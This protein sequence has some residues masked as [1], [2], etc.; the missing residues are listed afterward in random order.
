MPQL[1]RFVVFVLAIGAC[2]SRSPRAPVASALSAARLRCE[3]LVE[4]LGID[5]RI[6]RLSWNLTAD[7]AGEGTTAFEIDARDPSGAVAWASGKVTGPQTLQAE[8]SGRVLV[9]RE[10][11]TWKV[12]AWDNHDRPG[13]WSAPAHFEMGLLDPADWKGRWVAGAAS[14]DY[15]SHLPMADA[16]T[17]W[18]W[19]DG[20][21]RRPRYFRMVFD[22]PSGRTTKSAQGTAAAGDRFVL[23]ANGREVARGA[24]TGILSPVNLSL[25]AGRNVVTAQVDPGAG[26][27]GLLLRVLIEY[28]VGPPTELR[29]GRM[30]KTSLTAPPGW[31]GPAF[32]DRDWVASK[33]LGGR[34]AAPFGRTVLPAQALPAPLLRKTFTIKKKVVSARAYISGLGYFELYCNGQRVGDHVLD[35]GFTRYDRRVLYVTHDV[36]KALVAG[37]NAVGVILGNGFFNTHWR[38]A[39]AFQD[40]PWKM[41]P[42]LTAQIEVLYQDGTRDVVVTD[43]SWQASTGALVFDGVR[44]GEIFDARLDK[45][46]FSH[47]DFDA[48]SWPRALPVPG[49]KGVMS[50]QMAPPIRVTETIRPIAVTQPRPG[51][52]VFDMGQ[53]IAGWARLRVSGPAGTTVQLRYGER[54]HKDGLLDQAVI[55][56]HVQ[57][58]PFQTDTYVLRGDPKGGQETWEPRFVYH[59]FQYVEVSGFPGT[60]TVASLDGRAVNT[61]FPQIG[62]FD[63]SNVLLNQI[64]QATI[65]SYRSN[66]HSIPTDCPHREKNGW[67]ADAHLST[68]LAMFLFDNGPG[69]SKWVRDITDEQRSDG[70]L[71]GIVPTAGWGYDWG[72]GPAW[73]SA[74]LLVPWYMNLYL[75]DTRILTSNY[76]AFN[77]YASYLDG[78]DYRKK[79]PSGWLGDWVHLKQQTPEAVTHAGFQARDEDILAQTARL[80]GN[81]TEANRHQAVASRVRKDFQTRLL[82][83]DGKISTG[84]QTAQACALFEH[85][86]DAKAAPAVLKSL[87]ENL[88]GQGGHLEAG[89]LGT[90][91]LP[92]ALTAAGRADLVYR[93]V[94]HRDFPGWG[95]WFDQGATSLWEDWIGNDSRNHIFLGDI[96]AWFFR[97]LGGINPD[98]SEP[99]F[100]HVILRPEIVGDLTHAS[101]ETLSVRGRI[102]SAWRRDG[103]T[104]Q[105]TV[106]LPVGARGSAFVPAATRAAV[107]APGATWLRQEGDRQVFAVGAGTTAFVA[108]MP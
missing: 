8:W 58:G 48:R 76:S 107:T 108:T 67:M 42:R 21:E 52:F 25:Q 84:S 98:P 6:P 103:K 30:W 34:N 47:A 64:Y 66:F 71:P 97:A 45:P 62:Q 46:R 100:A 79:N 15:A 17:R 32:D 38:D 50:A 37:D 70:A 77:R 36:T 7:T 75:G 65:R 11:I 61:D 3:G 106:V 60:P 63:S 5:V 68:E 91:C 41:T 102:A 19:G 93:L 88:Q 43:D 29:S 24:G 44:N 49:P 40:A 78:V 4:P 12:R 18:I 95:H 57:Q 81:Q 59:G 54:L 20:A 1:N 26:P 35:P 27:A 104:L 10:R 94:N 69:Y 51:I 23:W 72:N 16:K 82:G 92:W 55:S 105:W 89:V 90:K 14:Q 28:Q 99:G 13:A 33:E 87:L 86:V 73:D 22:L 96:T 83:A 9:S 85:L 101:A 80:L 56:A 31:Q 2:A 39:W 74:L 53:N